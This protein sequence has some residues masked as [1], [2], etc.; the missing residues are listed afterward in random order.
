MNVN[1]FLHPSI[2]TILDVPALRK[3]IGK[4]KIIG[5]STHDPTEI[6]RA[7]AEGADYVGIGAVYGTKTKDLTREPIGTV[8]LKEILLA[9]DNKIPAVAIGGINPSNVQRVLYFS[10]TPEKNIKVSGVAVVSAIMANSDSAEASRVLRALIEE[11]PSWDLT[12]KIPWDEKFS[13]ENILTDISDLLSRVNAVKPLVHHITNDVVKNFSANVTIATGGSPV[14]SECVD[15]FSDFAEYP[16]AGCLINMG[17]P[18][19]EG[20]TLYRQAGGEYNKRGKTVV[21]DPVGA[22]ATRLRTKACLELLQ[23]VAF[24]VVKGNDGEIYAAAGLKSP[25]KQRGV[26][27]DTD[28]DNE[29]RFQ[30]A[31][32]LAQDYRTIVLMTGP[33]DL[34]VDEHGNA[35]IFANGSE[36]LSLITGSGCS[37]G[38]LITTVLATDKSLL[39]Q[40]EDRMPYGNFLATAAAIALY[41]VA[42]EQ[43]ANFPTCTGPGTFVP[44]FLDQLH[45]ISKENRLGNTKWLSRINIRPFKHD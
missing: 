12:A 16:N 45:A 29:A 10:A 20:V 9:A 36:Y 40:I 7:I 18:T 43:A 21:F 23:H 32:K 17:T 34:L 6:K 35:L 13:Q 5:V 31:Y 19:L 1:S 30:A 11:N 26:D 15:E 4:N 3:L 25:T 14:M 28:A 27:S 39:D 24:D 8:G 41:T 33:E 37:L 38:S 44:L 2:L 22:G 42:S